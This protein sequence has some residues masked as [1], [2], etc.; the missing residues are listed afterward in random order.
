[1]INLMILAPIWL[2]GVRFATKG[3]A[4]HVQAKK[5]YDKDLSDLGATWPSW[6]PTYVDHIAWL[7]PKSNKDNNQ[8]LARYITA[9]WGKIRYLAAKLQTQKALFVMIE[10]VVM[11][12]FMQP[13]I[14]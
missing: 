13:C 10:L 12:V 2:T 14:T 5:K 6:L 4:T 9:H 11:L 8:N 3:L 1:M 7:A